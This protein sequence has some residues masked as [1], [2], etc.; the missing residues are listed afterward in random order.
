MSRVFG[1]KFNLID[2]V[3][4]GSAMFWYQHIGMWFLLVL[5]AV[6]L[7]SFLGQVVL[8]SKK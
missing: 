2:V 7:V 6:E 4:I 8:E 1:R 5:F 3:N